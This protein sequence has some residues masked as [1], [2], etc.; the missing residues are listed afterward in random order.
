MRIDAARGGTDFLI[1]EKGVSSKGVGRI[2]SRESKRLFP[3]SPLPSIY[4]RG[5]WTAFTGSA[6]DRKAILAEVAEL[7][8]DG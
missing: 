1:V 6:R 7:I 8:S 3:E 2:Y 4:A 5:Y